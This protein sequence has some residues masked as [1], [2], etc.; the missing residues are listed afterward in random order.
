MKKVLLLMRR[1]PYGSV[2]SAEGLRSVMGLGVFEMD[3]ALAFAGDGVYVLK[4]GQNPQ[5]LEMKPLGEAFAGL[6]DFGVKQLYVHAPSL[7][8]RG[9]S[10][11][12]LVVP[13][14]LLDDAGLQ[15]LLAAQDVVLPF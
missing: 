2:Y 10:A 14:Q 15:Q 4:Q 13:A 12:D 5:A 8:E 1:A 9:L 6:E 3:V 11:A 7:A